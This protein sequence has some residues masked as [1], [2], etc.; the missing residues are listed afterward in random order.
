M[1]TNFHL[2][3]RF[4]EKENKE[5]AARGEPPLPDEGPPGA[6]ERGGEGGG[7]GKTAGGGAILGKEPLFKKGGDKA[8]AKGG[9]VGQ[10]AVQAEGEHLSQVCVRK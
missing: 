7:V 6:A 10:G 5:R 9:R 3:P 4:L 8:G 2:T 1:C